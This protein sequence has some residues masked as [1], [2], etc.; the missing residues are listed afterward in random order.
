M[1]V[2]LSS[3]HALL[4]DLRM[5]APVLTK[6]HRYGL[7]ITNLKFHATG[8]VVTADRKIIKIWDKKTGAPH[9]CTALSV[10]PLSVGQLAVLFRAKSVRC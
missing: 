9:C 10:C 5:S 1:G 8:N 4:Y 2:G 3:G 6:D 7:P